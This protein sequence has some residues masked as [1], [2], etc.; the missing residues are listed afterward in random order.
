MDKGKVFLDIGSEPI[1]IDRRYFEG[2]MAFKGETDAAIS[3]YFFAIEDSVKRYIP[4]LVNQCIEVV[5]RLFV[6]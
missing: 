2:F 1:M 3:A 6:I 5:V 4:E